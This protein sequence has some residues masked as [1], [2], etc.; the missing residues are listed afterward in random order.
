MRFER[1]RDGLR[2]APAR[3]ATRR[4]RA[5]PRGAPGGGRPLPEDILGRHDRTSPRVEPGVATGRSG[6]ADLPC[7]AAVVV[8]GAGRSSLIR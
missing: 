2:A 6:F 7:P 3:A 8:K 5:D 4:P 1:Q